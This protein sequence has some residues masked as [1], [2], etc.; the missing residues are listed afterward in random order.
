MKGLWQ[1]KPSIP[2]IN[3]VCKIPKQNAQLP[4]RNKYF[5][6]KDFSIASIVEDILSH[7]MT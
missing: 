7:I 4:M 6:N 5:Y 3:N 1:F 2:N